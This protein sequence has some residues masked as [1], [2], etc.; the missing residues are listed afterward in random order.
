MHS[1][2]L[3]YSWFCVGLTTGI[4]LELS[5]VSE[6][7]EPRLRFAGVSRFEFVT[8]G[9]VEVKRAPKKAAGVLLVLLSA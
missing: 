9:M 8:G 4:L 2:V 5:N 6:V 3:G 7:L 1:I